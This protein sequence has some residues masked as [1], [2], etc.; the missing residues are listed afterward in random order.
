M[1]GL[2]ELGSIP[3]VGAGVL[4]SAVAMDKAMMKVAFAGR[5]LPMVAHVVV[6]RGEWEADPQGVAAR[7]ADRLGL[8]DV[9]Q[10]GQPRVE[11]RHLEGEDARGTG[12]RHRDRGRVRPEDRRRG[13]GPDRARD[14]VLGAR[15]TTSPRR[16]CRAKSCR[17]ASSTT[18][19]RSTSRS[20]RTLI[21][22]PLDAATT[23]EVRRLAVEAFLAVDCAG[24]RARGL[25]PVARDAAGST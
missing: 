9:R 23:A 8:P 25:P 5:G 18:T 24:L 4:A 14:R 21:P 7:L 19:T 12:R 11:R 3:Y 22:A 1:Q 15:A 20:R 16:R 6:L 10:A 2:L 13:G 17:R